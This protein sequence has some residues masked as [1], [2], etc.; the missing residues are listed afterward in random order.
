MKIA[1][2]YQ[3]RVSV[4][5]SETDDGEASWWIY[6]NDGWCWEPGL[7]T[8]HE[9]TQREALQCLRETIPCDCDGCKRGEL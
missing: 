4:I 7:H 6:L 5:E 8:I 2:K 9:D 3:E 1:K